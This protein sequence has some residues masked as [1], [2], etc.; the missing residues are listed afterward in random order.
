MQMHRHLRPDLFTRSKK[1]SKFNVIKHL[2]AFDLARGHT[3]IPRLVQKIDV[4]L[5]LRPDALL[6]G[7]GLLFFSRVGC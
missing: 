7:N 5:R 3:R 4:H 1:E 2:P 6:S